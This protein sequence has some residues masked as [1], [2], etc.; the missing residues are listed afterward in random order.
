MAYNKRDVKDRIVQYP[1]RYQLNPVDGGENIYDLVPITGTVTEDGTKLN[2]AYL[3]PLEDILDGLGNVTHEIATKEEAEVGTSNVRYMTPLR[4]K[5]GSI[6]F[7]KE[8]G[9][10]NTVFPGDNLIILYK[11][12]LNPSVLY[13]YTGELSASYTIYTKFIEV[14]MKYSGTFRIS[15]LLSSGYSDKTAYANIFKNGV[16][17]GIERSVYG[18]NYIAFVQDIYFDKND[19]LEIRC[20][21]SISSAA[22]RINQFK[23]GIESDRNMLYALE[24]STL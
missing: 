4:V 7:I 23:I 5:E 9:F 11:S 1:R 17:V 8:F 12:S 6:N 14:K 16:A 19:I 24:Y 21:S 3:Q 10:L 22:V 13:T 18:S 2:K 15:F 20:K